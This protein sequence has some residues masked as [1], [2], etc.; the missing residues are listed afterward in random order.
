M[1]YWKSLS[2]L[3][4]VLFIIGMQ[5]QFLHVITIALLTTAVLSAFR[6]QKRSR[7]I[8]ARIGRALYRRTDF[9]VE[10]ET[11]LMD[12]KSRLWELDSNEKL[13]S[14]I[15]R[16]GDYIEEEL[17]TLRGNGVVGLHGIPDRLKEMTR[18][19][20][21]SLYHMDATGH[22]QEFSSGITRMPAPPVWILEE[23]LQRHLPLTAIEMSPHEWPELQRHPGAHKSLVSYQR[24]SIHPAGGE[25]A[26]FTLA[27]VLGYAHEKS[28]LPREHD[29]LVEAVRVL[30]RT[31]R[32]FSV[33]SAVKIKGKEELEQ[34]ERFFAHVSHDIRTPL[35]NIQ[36]I[37]DLFFLE[38]VTPKNQHFLKVARANCRSL[39][40]IVEE[41]LEFTKIKNGCFRSHPEPVSLSTLIEEVRS[42]FMLNAETK[43]LTLTSITH[44]KGVVHADRKQLKRVLL[45]LV[46]NALKYTDC[47]GVTLRLAVVG[48]YVHVEVEDTGHGIPNEKL[49][50][51]FTP[52]VRL[53]EGRTEGI[54]LGLV[55]TQLLVEQNGGRIDV[56]S[57]VGQGSRFSITFPAVQEQS[58]TKEISP[59]LES[60][61]RNQSAYRNSQAIERIRV[62]ILDDDI[63]AGATL[64][65]LLECF[66]LEVHATS[67]LKELRELLCFWTPHVVITDVHMPD[68][69]VEQVLD[70]VSHYE[71]HGLIALTG[72]IDNE[73]LQEIR[74]LGISTI[75][76]KPAS[77]EAILE[78]IDGFLPNIE[79]PVSRLG[80]QQADSSAMQDSR[81]L[82]SLASSVE[83]R[84]SA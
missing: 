69:Q 47:G 84:R 15:T 12:L 1:K 62:A 5:I 26:S 33:V 68:C 82:N 50:D 66:S 31:L 41:L 67:S 42:E 24:I 76:R 21:I 80:M 77:P 53:D 59:M 81:E 63:D 61:K 72:C 7:E 36:S 13:G 11:L 58:V 40:D 56:S 83:N 19:C 10:P 34:Q 55:L 57:V 20:S 23:M 45:N 52:F 37:L 4:C 70:S 43:N 73:Q 51:L 27:I 79:A 74:A 2:I 3:I 48:E 9:R 75:L 8:I 64:A 65:T 22:L 6:E 39:R 46:S 16:F 60:L 78:A 44:E 49:Q 35:N 25:E 17:Q 28:P 29:I 32:E 54:G 18:A 71:L 38:G 14:K 30:A